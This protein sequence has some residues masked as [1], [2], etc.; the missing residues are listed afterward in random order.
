MYTHAGL[1]QAA[2]ISKN[3]RQIKENNLNQAET[4]DIENQDLL[5]AQTLSLTKRKQCKE[6][7]VEKNNLR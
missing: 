3:L 6:K 5:K 7:F 4:T 1:I 2:Y